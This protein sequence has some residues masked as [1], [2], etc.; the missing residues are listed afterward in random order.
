MDEEKKKMIEALRGTIKHWKQNV[1]VLG[2]KGKFSSGEKQY[3][4]VGRKQVWYNSHHCDLCAIF[5]N[6]GCSNCPLYLA[7]NNC[8]SDNSAWDKVVN[9]KTK[10][11]VLKTS[12]GMLKVLRGLLKQHTKGRK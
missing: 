6:S 8:N 5:G 3:F 12:R 1:K 4:M 2:G 11:R 9:S 7:D 10:L